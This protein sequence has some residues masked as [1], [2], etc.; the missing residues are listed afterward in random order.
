MG[1]DA[2][3]L[4]AENAAIKERP[5]S[6]RLDAGNIAHMKT[7]MQRLGF[8]YRLEPRNHHLRARVLPLES[9]V[10][11]ENVRAR[12]RVSQRSAAELVPGMRDGAG[13]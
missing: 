9:V 12:S 2:F 7:Q 6:A 10:L 4:P 1:W 13:Q 5:P 8:G 3:G 11:F